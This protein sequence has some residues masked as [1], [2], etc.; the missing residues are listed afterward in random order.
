MAMFRVRVSPQRIGCAQLEAVCETTTRFT[1]YVPVSPSPLTCKY[2]K[3]LADRA[4]AGQ[5][6]RRGREEGRAC[7]SPR[8]HAASAG[9][10]SHEDASQMHR[11]GRALRQ[12]TTIRYVTVP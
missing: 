3:S 10:R 5:E 11:T 2:L 8:R 1:S 6:G 12:G 7:R 4:R 9:P